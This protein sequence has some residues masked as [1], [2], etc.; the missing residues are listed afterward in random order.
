MLTSFCT[1]HK[2]VLAQHS[3]QVKAPKAAC[4]RREA[5]LLLGGGGNAV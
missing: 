4:D 5:V 2:L 1:K 3:S